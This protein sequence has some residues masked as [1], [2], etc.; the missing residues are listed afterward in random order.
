MEWTTATDGPEAVAV[1]S[2]RGGEVLI[3][4][5]THPGQWLVF[6][7]AEWR[8]FTEAVRSGHFDVVSSPT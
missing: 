2:S 3:R 7:G 6:P 4:N 5:P 8:A 1:T